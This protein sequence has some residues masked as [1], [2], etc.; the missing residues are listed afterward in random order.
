MA[1]V[2]AI[3]VGAGP[4]GLTAAVTLARAG[5]SVRVY[6]GAAT[7]GGGARTAELTLPGFR[8]DP[9]S[10]VHPLGAGSPVLSGLGLERFGLTWVHPELPLAHPF[11]DGSAAVLARSVDET[12]DSLGDDFGDH[13][14]DGDAYRRLLG[15]FLGRWDALAA[16]VLRAPL[17]GWP[18]QPLLYGRFGLRAVL[19]AEVLGRAFV[20][21]RGRGLLA[22]LAGHVTAPLTSPVTGG[23]AL[24]FALAAHDVGWPFPRGGTQA[25]PDALAGLLR[26]LG[27]TIE[28]GHQ[29]RALGELPSARAYLFDTDPAAAAAIAGQRLPSWYADLVLRRYRHGPAVFKVDYALSGPVPWIAQAARRAGTVHLGPTMAEIAAALRSAQR[30]AEPR[31]P[32]LITAQ[33]SLFD[34]RRA[35]AGSHVFWVYAQ[36]PNGW[37]GDLVPAVEQ[38]I[39]RFATG[40]RDLVLARTVTTPADIEAGNPNNVGGDIAGGRC[41]GLR[42][43]LRPAPVPVPVPYA[44]PDP[45]IYLCS[46]A[47]PPGPGVHG[48]CGYHAARAALRRVFRAPVPAEPSRELG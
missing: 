40:F 17:D 18:R 2:D 1:D 26:S 36:V 3:V 15:P 4:N 21:E 44:T 39:E 28:T 38:Q 23:I 32:F 35:P 42:L 33:P 27:G 20:G 29:V 30:G 37:R 9:C 6:E 5:L 7:I 10:A 13:G 24:M 47:T 31:P 22:G 43:L 34:D 48:M 8:H 25:I 19:P 41:D 16:D 46:S 12:A 14:G 11:P 45:A